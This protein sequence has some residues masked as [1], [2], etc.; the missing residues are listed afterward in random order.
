[1]TNDVGCTKDSCGSAIIGLAQGIVL[2]VSG[3]A[4][5]WCGD[6]RSVPPTDFL[7]GIVSFLAHRQ[8]FV[9]KG[10]IIVRAPPS[11]SRPHG[12]S[13]RWVGCYVPSISLV[14]QFSLLWA[15]HAS[16]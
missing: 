13:G 6:V 7:R 14:D 15:E 9:G 2:R 10:E 8:Q 1:M 12:L 11:I 16:D 5:P 3:L 4:V